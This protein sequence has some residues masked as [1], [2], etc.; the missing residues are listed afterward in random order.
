VAL[1]DPDNIIDTGLLNPN[2]RVRQQI[3]EYREL[4]VQLLFVDQT[5]FGRWRI[6]PQSR[7][8]LDMAIRRKLDTSI[9]R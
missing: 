4:R 6:A 8:D 5:G 1:G 3:W 2:E 9:N 7:V